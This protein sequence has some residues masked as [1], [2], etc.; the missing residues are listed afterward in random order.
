MRFVSD[1]F[2]ITILKPGHRSVWSQW[3]LGK[4][5]PDITP[6]NLRNRSWQNFPRTE[7]R[8]MLMCTRHSLGDTFT[9]VPPPL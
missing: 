5:N 6:P 9:L 1:E 7:V 2:G 8:L 4:Q 3:L